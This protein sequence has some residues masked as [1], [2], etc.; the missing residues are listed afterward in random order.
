MK[1]KNTETTPDSSRRKKSEQVLKQDSGRLQKLSA[2]NDQKLI[3]ELQAYKIELEVK[4]EELRSAQKQI[5][6]SRRKY[7]DLYDFAPVGYF[8]FNQQGLILEVNL[9]GA[10]LLQTKKSLLIKKPFPPFVHNNYRD[11]FYSHIRRVFDSGTRQTCE[12]II[13]MKPREHTFI[14]RYVQLESVPARDRTGNLSSLRTII[15]DINERKLMEEQLTFAKEEWEQTFDLIPDLIVVTDDRFRI[16]KAN[17]A[18]AEQA[19][20]KR[21]ELIGKLCYQVIHGTDEPPGHCSHAKTLS[22]GSENIMDIYEDHLKNHYMLST[23]PIHGA[24]GRVSGAVEVFRN[25]TRRKEIEK[26]LLDTAITDELTGLLNRRGF[27]TLAEQQ[28]MLAGRTHRNMILLYLDVNN[29]KK[30][31]DEHGHSRGDQILVSAARILKETFR[32]SDIIGRIGGDEFVVLI[33][34]PSEP[35]IEHVIRSHI[36]D[37][38]EKHRE[39][40]GR[41]AALSFSMGFAKFD[42]DNVCSVERL[43][44]RADTLM[45][46]D[47]SVF[48]SGERTQSAGMEQRI[49]RS[50][51]RLKVINEYRAELDESAHMKVKNISRGGICI[52]GEKPLIADTIHTITIISPATG[53]AETYKAVAVWSLSAVSDTKASGHETGMKFIELTDSLSGHLDSLI[54]SLNV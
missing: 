10:N 47:K 45:Y 31:N 52:T 48:R 32:K 51:Q 5:E 16:T 37:N 36:H 26:K 24:D 30:I 40:S 15:S 27:F 4:N 25:I 29:L 44:T 35:D 22:E 23:S 28:C 38:L 13:C 21:E 46:K 1:K 42:P 53:I 54:T 7:A 18:L 20:M 49:T 43:L 17:K 41:D 14:Q 19:G 2:D 12:I 3:R 33:T 9:T 8:T 34:E 6:E 39:K 50:H 11:M